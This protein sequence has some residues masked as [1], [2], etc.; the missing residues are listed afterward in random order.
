MDLGQRSD[1]E[2]QH[3]EQCA[4]P[5]TL[6]SCCLDT[7]GIGTQGRKCVLNVAP[8]GIGL[9]K[10]NY[11]ERAASIMPHFRFGKAF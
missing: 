10:A 5:E 1:F 9:H 3:Y 2:E 11:N 8:W 4:L 6:E 7:T